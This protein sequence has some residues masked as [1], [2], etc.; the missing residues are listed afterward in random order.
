MIYCV[1]DD[2]NLRELALYALKSSGFK[3]YGF[4]TAKEFWQAMGNEKPSLVLLDIMLPD[5]D[6]LS[7]LKRLRENPDTRSLPIIMATAKGTEYDKVM[8]LESGAD[9]Y[10]VKPFGMMEMISRIRAVLR[11]AGIQ[12]EEPQL[13]LGDMVLDTRKHTVTIDNKPLELTMKEYSLLKLFMSNLGRAFTRDQLLS[14]VWGEEYF[15]ET[16]TVDVHISTLRAKLGPYGEYIRTVRGLG[17][18]MEGKQ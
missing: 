8:G 17:Y 11:R 13:S 2:R 10:L 6:G 12:E 7:I 16:R 1:E 18:R 14:S 3:A 9:D 15:G 5:E 4:E